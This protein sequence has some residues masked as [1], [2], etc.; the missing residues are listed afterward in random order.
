LDE[1]KEV[2]SQED[3]CCSSAGGQFL[4]LETQDGG[5]GHFLII[6]TERWALDADNIDAFAEQLK[7]FINRKPANLADLSEH[8]KTTLKNEKD[9]PANA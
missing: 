3:D 5:G 7:R 2:Y 9:K 4:E 1:W 6:K 8:F